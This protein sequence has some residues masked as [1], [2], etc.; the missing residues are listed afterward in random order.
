MKI[1]LKL[2]PGKPIDHLSVLDEIYSR[3]RAQKDCEDSF[4]VTLDVRYSITEKVFIIKA[5][6]GYL[7]EEEFKGS[8][9]TELVRKALEFIDD[10]INKIILA[11]L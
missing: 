4:V 11:N 6:L 8:D 1:Q 2:K 7:F 5:N 9:L 10:A 3:I